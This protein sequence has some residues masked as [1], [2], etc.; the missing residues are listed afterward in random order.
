M[1]QPAVD[2]YPE[3]P[4]QETV[5]ACLL[6][7]THEAFES[8]P[9]NCFLDSTRVLSSA[10]MTFLLEQSLEVGS[11]VPEEAPP[12]SSFGVWLQRLL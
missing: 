6:E 8:V 11:T 1:F 4:S 10:S 3:V 12:F 5:G 2:L 9:T 7:L